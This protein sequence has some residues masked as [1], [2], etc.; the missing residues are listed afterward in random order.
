[1]AALLLDIFSSEGLENYFQ[2]NNEQ[3]DD[4]IGNTFVSV[5]LSRVHFREPTGNRQKIAEP[6][7]AGSA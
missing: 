3:S 1:M 7:L 4:G 6:L 2:G 5:L